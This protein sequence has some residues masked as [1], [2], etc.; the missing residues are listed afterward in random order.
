[1]FWLFFLQIVYWS[2]SHERFFYSLVCCLTTFNALKIS[3]FVWDQ[4][5]LRFTLLTVKRCPSIFSSLYIFFCM[6][7]C[8]MH[9]ASKWREDCAKRLR[10]IWARNGV[11]FQWYEHIVIKC[12]G[13]WHDYMLKPTNI[14][15]QFLL[16]KTHRLP[17]GHITNSICDNWSLLLLASSEL[18]LRSV[19]MSRLHHQDTVA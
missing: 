15:S 9:G 18:P 17:L 11:S 2:V 1:M 12:E 13:T 19:Y 16:V 7:G 10:Q 8:A 3:S 4:T 14:L 5:S 6:D